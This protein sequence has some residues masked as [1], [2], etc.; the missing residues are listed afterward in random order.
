LP[1]GERGTRAKCI[2]DFLVDPLTDI[3]SRPC[4]WSTAGRAWGPVSQSRV[5]DE[6]K[7]E[8]GRMT[9]PS[10]HGEGAQIAVHPSADR[11]EEFQ[12]LIE[13]AANFAQLVSGS[14]IYSGSSLGYPTRKAEGHCRL[15]GRYGDLTFEHIPP[16]SAANSTR[17]RFG[18]AR[19]SI[20]HPR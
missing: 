18:Q 8:N 4:N 20:G 6:P 11:L 12:T 9:A 14:E 15:C 3:G 7:R 16:R 10:G 17:W 5:K 2:S 13:D 19:T 1:F